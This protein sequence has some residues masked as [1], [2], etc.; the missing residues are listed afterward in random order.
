MPEGFIVGSHR[1]A[2]FGGPAG[3]QRGGGGLVAVASAM[4]LKSV[5]IFS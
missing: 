2:R 4:S 3:E 5:A 1:G